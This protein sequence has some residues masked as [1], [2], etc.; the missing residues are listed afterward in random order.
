MVRPPFMA[1]VTVEYDDSRLRKNI[2]DL[3]R[4]INSRVGAVV[5]FDAAWG[6]G[7]MRQAAPW[8]DRTGAAR[9]GLF[10]IPGHFGSQHEIF[11]TYSV[12]YGIWL[13]IANSGR[14]QVLQPMLRIIG[15]K[16]MSD[17]KHVFG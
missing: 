15:N 13:E 17:M 6:E 5:D 3:P 8:T 11:L 2:H 16:A 1:R 7:A 10:A 9:G 14:Y 4:E 12:Y